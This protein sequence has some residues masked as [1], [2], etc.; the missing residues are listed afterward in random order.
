MVYTV[1]YDDDVTD[2][3]PTH[4]SRVAGVLETVLIALH[5]EL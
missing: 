1:Q 2:L 4:I 5:E 3:K